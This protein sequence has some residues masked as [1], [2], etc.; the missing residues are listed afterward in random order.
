MLR[1]PNITRRTFDRIN[2]VSHFAIWIPQMTWCVGAAAYFLGKEDNEVVEKFTQINMVLLTLGLL[3]YDY[4]AIFYENHEP[5]ARE[6]TGNNAPMLGRPLYNPEGPAEKR[7]DVEWPDI[8]LHTGFIVPAVLLAQPLFGGKDNPV[9][10]YAH[11]LFLAYYPLWSAG[12][13]VHTH[14]N[15]N[16]QIGFELTT[17]VGAAL[18]AFACVMILFEAEESSHIYKIT[19][20]ILQLITGLIF[21]A[22]NVCLALGRMKC[23]QGNAAGCVVI[24]DENAQPSA[25]LDYGGM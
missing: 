5:V 11:C 22:S 17:K 9:C 25:R 21:V 7:I 23:L 4:S 16:L 20:N 1:A 15:N 18:A 10:D 8:I 24:T 12:T 3:L 6:A 14:T 13:K 2:A 19:S